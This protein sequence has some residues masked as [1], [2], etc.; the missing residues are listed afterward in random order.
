MR[1][2]HL[3]STKNLVE[4]LTSYAYSDPVFRLRTQL[5]DKSVKG[6]AD[7][8]ERALVPDRTVRLLAGILLKPDTSK[9]LGED[10]AAEAL[11]IVRTLLGLRRPDTSARCGARIKTALPCGHGVA[12]EETACPLAAAGGSPYCT[13]HALED[14]LGVEFTQTGPL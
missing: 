3:N 8:I 13:R 11:A 10:G 6:V 9:R 14:W 2:E 1:E 5:G 7:M 4:N 12:V